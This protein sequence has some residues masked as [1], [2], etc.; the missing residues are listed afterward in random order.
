MNSRK[1][2]E[3]GAVIYVFRGPLRVR[4]YLVRPGGDLEEITDVEAIQREQRRVDR[5]PL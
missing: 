1:V 5:P 3:S 2:Y 4:M